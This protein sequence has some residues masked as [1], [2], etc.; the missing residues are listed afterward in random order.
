MKTDTSYTPIEN[1]FQNFVCAMFA[2]ESL[3]VAQLRTLRY[4]WFASA[5]VAMNLLGDKPELAETIKAELLDFADQQDV[6]AH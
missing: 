6:W 3:S 5:A 1:E 4:N 2:G